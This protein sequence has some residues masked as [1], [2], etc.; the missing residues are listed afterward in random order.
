M[1]RESSSIPPKKD[2]SDSKQNQELDPGL[3]KVFIKNLYDHYQLD[4]S[5][6]AQASLSRRIKHLI[7][8]FGLSGLDELNDKIKNEPDFKISLVHEITVGATEMF[9]DST[10]WIA[11]REGILSGIIRDKG[12]IKFWISGCST[13]EEIFSLA[14]VLKELDIFNRAEILATDLDPLVID[15]A[16]KGYYFNHSFVKNSENY[17]KSKGNKTLDFYCKKG[18]MGYQMDLSLL[19]NV[20]FKHND[21]VQESIEGDFDLIFCRNV[22]I[23]F[24]QE[25]QNKVL[26]KLRKNLQPGSYLALGVKESIM[27]LKDSN[28]FDPIKR[29]EKIYQLKENGEKT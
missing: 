16:R 10:F 21:L 6:Y 20:I 19:E 12:K 23:Y 13:G 17:I 8:I 14:I 26:N 28:Q 7:T 15:I 3:I 27:W 5:N 24:N 11:L 18:G 25:L 4:L 9:R 2:R 22:M 1:A 29:F